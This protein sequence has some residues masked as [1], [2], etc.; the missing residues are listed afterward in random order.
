MD[1]SSEKFQSRKNYNFIEKIQLIMI[2]YYFK[3]ANIYKLS[4]IF[5]FIKLLF[6]ILKYF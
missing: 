6:I 2:N 1:L 5:A 3:R 4:N